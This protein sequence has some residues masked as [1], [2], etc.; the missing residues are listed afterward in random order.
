VSQESAE[1]SWT[2]DYV[3]ASCRKRDVAAGSCGSPFVHL[4]FP[5]STLW[6]PENGKRN[7]RGRRSLYV[8]EMTEAASAAE[9]SSIVS[10]APDCIS[11]IWT[12]DPGEHP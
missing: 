10:A 12:Q 1:A 2:S 9:S 3:V 5:I 7:A 4:P 6:P 8:K 11:G